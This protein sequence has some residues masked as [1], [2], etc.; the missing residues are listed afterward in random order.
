M[1]CGLPVI[2]SSVND[3]PDI[4]QHGVNGFLIDPNNTQ[5]FIK[6]CNKLLDNKTLYLEMG[7]NARL[8]IE[9]MFKTDFSEDAQQEC[10]FKFLNATIKKNEGIG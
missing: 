3:I 1:S 6:A 9:Q 8:S 5:G 10:W 2:S 7:T 4:I